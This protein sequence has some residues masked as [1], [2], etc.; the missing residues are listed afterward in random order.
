MTAKTKHG[1]PSTCE[2]PTSR[3]CKATKI[4]RGPDGSRIVFDSDRKG[5]REV[6]VVDRDCQNPTRLAHEQPAVHH[7]AWSPD[8]TRI[9]YVSANDIYVIDVDG[10]NATRL[11]GAHTERHSPAWSA[12]GSRIAVSARETDGTHIFV[13]D[14]DDGATTQLNHGRASDAQPA[15]SAD[16]SRIAFG[17]D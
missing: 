6:Y 12:D 15:W 11:L 13:M 8:G 16:A 10:G 14:L 4:P 3:A 1:S 2:S 7:P 9:A 17:S 5:H